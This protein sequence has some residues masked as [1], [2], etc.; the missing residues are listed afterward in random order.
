MSRKE[1][2][3]VWWAVQRSYH[4]D[5]HDADGKLVSTET[6]DEWKARILKEWAYDNPAINADFVCRIFHGRDVEPQTGNPKGL[7][8]HAL[9]HLKDGKTQTAMMAAMGVTRAQ[10]CAPVRTIAGAARYLIHVSEEALREKKTIYLPDEVDISE[11]KPGRTRLADLMSGKADA[12]EARSDA[13]KRDEWLNYYAVCL[14]RGELQLDEVKAAIVNDTEGVGFTV[15]DWKRRRAAFEVDEKE[16]LQQKTKYFIRQQHK[17][18]LALLY[19]EGRGGAG[20]TTLASALAENWADARGVHIVAAP[21]NGTTFDFA[22]TY[23]GEKVSVFNEMSGSAFGVD[24]FCAVF[25]PK[26]ATV[27][28]SRFEDKAWLA[29][30]CILTTSREFEGFVRDCWL[31]YAKEHIRGDVLKSCETDDD[32]DKAYTSRPDVAD[33]I[34]QVRRRFCVRVVLN[35]NGQAEIYLLNEVTNLPKL[36]DRGRAYPP[37]QEPFVL[38]QTLPYNDRDEASVAAVVAAITAAVEEYYRRNNYSVTPWMDDGFSSYMNGIVEEL[39]APG[40]L[41]KKKAGAK[42]AAAAAAGEDVD[43]G[44]DDDEEGEDDG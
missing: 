17:R 33:K 8:A 23:K 29:N 25:D 11:E 16:Y 40:K 30:Y 22:G 44:L 39:V 20:K 15:D 34:R 14:M 21:G 36:Y 6:E 3:P 4:Y 38:F 32:W 31:P 35:G 5:T 1:P 9:V 12:K 24:Q 27:A 19:I 7:H 2:R 42:S 28:N 10:S 26:F 13:E 43:D 37:G 18:G 41:R